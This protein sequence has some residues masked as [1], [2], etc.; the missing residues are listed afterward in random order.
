MKITLF[1]VVL[2]I[3]VAFAILIFKILKETVS[4]FFPE[5]Y[6]SLKKIYPHPLESVRHA[7]GVLSTRF[8]FQFKNA[9]K[10]DIYEDKLIVSY[11]GKGVILPYHLYVFKTSKFFLIHPLTIENLPI[12]S[13][14]ANF[15]G[16]IFLGK[17]S[18]A[19]LTIYLS[20]KRINRILQLAPK[21]DY[22]TNKPEN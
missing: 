20:Q 22:L 5:D 2:G 7:S 10:V 17:A 16:N 13:Q 15:F 14:S 9:L 11:L 8:P 3:V 12:A 21:D 6:A 1:F 4:L 19:N 18:F